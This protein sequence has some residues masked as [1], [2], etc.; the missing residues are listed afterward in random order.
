MMLQTEMEQFLENLDHRLA[1]IEQKLPALATKD[2]LGRFATKDDLES[3]F[4]ESKRYALMLNESTRDDIR[5]VA[6]GVALLTTQVSSLTA[7]FSF[8]T[9]QF[10]SLTTRLEAKGVI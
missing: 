8:L 5:I 6:E 3:A 4:G 2:D 9:A 10:S 7:Q 1:R